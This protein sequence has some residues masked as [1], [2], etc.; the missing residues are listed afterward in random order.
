MGVVRMENWLLEIGK[1]FVRL[2]LNPLLYWFVLITFFASLSRIKRERKQFGRKVYPIFD[3][4]YGQRLRGLLFGLLISIGLTVL[5]VGLHPLML[6]G[7]VCL[8]ML[9]TVSKRFT[10]LSSAYIFGFTA[11]I[12]LFLPFYQS[13]LPS[14]F[15]TELTQIDWVIFTTL[16]GIFLIIE[17]LMISSV[18]RDQTFPELINSSRGKVVGQHRFKKII[19]IPLFFIWPIGSLSIVSNWWPVIEWSG[20]PFGLIIFP[21]IIGFDFSVAGGLPTKVAKRN[22]EYPL[23]LGFLIVALSL[24][25]YYVK[26]LTIVSV[27]VAIVGRE[28]ISYRL[29]IKDQQQPPLFSPLS[30]GLKVLA[31]LPG[32]PAIELGLI[33]GDTIKKVNGRSVA[34]PTEFYQALQINRAFCKLDIIDE[35]GEIRFAQRA[36]YQGEHHELGVIFVENHQERMAESI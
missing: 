18:T 19:L 11:I 29:K 31:I 6:A 8:T 7:I 15:Q 30:N 13:Y 2:L 10:L 22:S 17:G 16:M 23:L 34:T 14:L 26:I 33:P 4:W 3:E 21:F 35:R 25:S 36:F 1:A 5:G 28:F 24:M 12:L 32:T 9:F 20:L 27:L